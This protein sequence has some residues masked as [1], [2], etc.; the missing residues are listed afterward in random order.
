MLPWSVGLGG[1]G[2]ARGWL[3]EQTQVYVVTRSDC[4][5]SSLV[6]IMSVTCSLQNTAVLKAAVRYRTVSATASH[7]YIVNILG[8]RVVRVQE[9]GIYIRCGHNNVNWRSAGTFGHWMY[10]GAGNF[11]V[12]AVSRG[13]PRGALQKKRRRRPNL[14]SRASARRPSG[15]VARAPRTSVGGNS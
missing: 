1:R 14:V 9:E 12:F 11:P 5:K 3:I 10:V 4:I 7:S 13:S 6:V 2:T 15:A 8:V